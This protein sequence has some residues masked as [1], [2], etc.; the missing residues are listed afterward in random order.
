MK[1]IVIYDSLGG[2]TDKAARSI[3]QVL[4]EEGLLPDIMKVDRE[5]GVSGL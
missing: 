5:T 2:N 1:S 4:Q 3:H